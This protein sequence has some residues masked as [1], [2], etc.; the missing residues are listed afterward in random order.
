MDR[1]PI[2]CQSDRLGAELAGRIG[3][4]VG[5]HHH[6]W[7]C[8]R[9]TTITTIPTTRPQHARTHTRTRTRTPALMAESTRGRYQRHI[10]HRRCVCL[11]AQRPMPTALHQPLG[12]RTGPCP[13]QCTVLPRAHRHITTHRR[14][15]LP[16]QRE[17]HAG[18]ARILCHAAMPPG[19]TV[20]VA[21][22]R[23]IFSGGYNP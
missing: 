1:Q 16:A 4:V 23:V 15:C 19:G 17:G 21:K 3:R 13:V 14:V 12:L 5:Y 2:L 11:P 6:H 18:D 10:T 22:K 7:P 9:N 8:S 20:R